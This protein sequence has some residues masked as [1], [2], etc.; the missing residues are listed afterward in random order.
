MYC[1][2]CEGYFDESVL[3]EYTLTFVNDSNLLQVYLCPK[4]KGLLFYRYINTEL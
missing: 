2:E 4:C 3:E 1:D